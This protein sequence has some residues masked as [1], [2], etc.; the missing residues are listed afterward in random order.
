ML[1]KLT[2]SLLN[3]TP[4]IQQKLLQLWSRLLQITTFRSQPQQQKQ[5]QSKPDLVQDRNA[6]SNISSLLKLLPLRPSTTS[7]DSTPSKKTLSTADKPPIEISLWNILSEEL[8]EFVL[9]SNVV[10]MTEGW[11][12][13]Y[14]AVS[15]YPL[16]FFFHF[17]TFFL[18]RLEPFAFFFTL[19]ELKLFGRTKSELAH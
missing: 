4:K 3:E 8:K 1:L 14:S 5:K 18:S 19:E 15:F 6:L 13:D 2:P 9:R 11:N 7:G 16:P 12:E 17:N 10:G